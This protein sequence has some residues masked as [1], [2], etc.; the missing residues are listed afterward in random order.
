MYNPNIE[1]KTKE[2]KMI[3]VKWDLKGIYF[4]C[5][6]LIIRRLKYNATFI[7]E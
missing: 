6:E 5:N 7:L 3:Y 1:P 4:R 2:N